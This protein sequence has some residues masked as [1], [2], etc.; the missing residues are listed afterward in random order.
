MAS[1]PHFNLIVAIDANGGIAKNGSMPWNHKSDMKF[2]RDTTIGAG[3]NAVIMGRVTYESIPPAHRP[4]NERLNV[5]VSSTWRQEDKQGITVVPTFVDAL[6]TLGNKRYDTIWVIGGETLYLSVI[7][8]YLY[9]CDKMFITRFKTDYGC[10]KYFP[11]DEVKNFPKFQDELKT[12]DYT[13]YYLK[14]SKDHQEYR[15]IN[16]LREI[17][18]SGDNRADRTGVGTKS[19]FAKTLEFD[20]SERIPLLTVK[21]MVYE[22]VLK[23][24]LF[25][26]SGSTDTKE[27]EAVGVNYWRGNTSRKFLDDR[28][29]NY[30]E[31][32]MGPCFVAGTMI[33]TQN[34][35]KKIEDVLIDDMLY[36]HTGE[37]HSICNLQQRNF[38]GDLF[39]IKARYHPK[40][41]CTDEHPFYCRKYQIKREGKE[42]KNTVIL[43]DPEWI[44]AKDLDKSYL[45]GMPIEQT[46][47]TP[48][49]NGL[50]LD[51]PEYWFM[52][53]YFLGDGWIQ[54]PEQHRIHFAIAD[55]QNN[56]IVSKLRQVLN[57]AIKTSEKTSKC[58]V[59]RVGNK[60]WYEIL[61]HFGKYAHGKKI[62]EWV[63]KAPKNLIEKFLDGYCSADGCIRKTKTNES[64][65]FTTVSP[66]IAYSLQRLYLKLGK[67]ASIS[68]QKRSYK[69]KFSEQRE[70]ESFYRDCYFIEI[71]DSPRRNNYSMIDG[72]HAWFAISNIQKEKTKTKVFNFEVETDNSYIA[73][74]L[75][76]HNCYGFQWRFW[77]AE[78]EGAHENYTGKGIDQL[79]NLICGLRDD[80]LSRR[81][82]MTCLNVADFDRMVLYPCHHTVQFYVSSDR[83]HLDCMM[84]QRSGDMAL[85]VP[86]NIFMYAVLTYMIAHVCNYKPRK[87][88]ITIGDA[89][90]Y[91]SHASGVERMLD[92][93]PRPWATLRFKDPDKI[94]DIDQ[95]KFDNFI[96]ENYT[97]WPFIQLQMAV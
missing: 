95:F 36:T 67:F 17:Y 18:F 86:T 91:N 46:E 87:L 27:L 84:H 74:N 51:K 4:L 42:R 62:P 56:N 8:D 89:H 28:K 66:D 31:G 14:P 5:V 33:A 52:M 92:R 55:S 39:T 70:K 45:I 94:R 22:S 21:K 64:R 59:Y 76:V 38:A 97:S 68:F 25:F 24:I 29:L 93:T 26:V 61:S 3:K 1:L 77:G 60:Q 96:I 49:I 37:L 79:R 34:G 69:K 57:I 16:L 7:K 81:H 30:Q 35:Y 43:D 58:E 13:R 85:G 47:E 41:Q 19:M 11:W 65:R 73:N 83:Q 54:E 12:Q 75:A 63:H 2:F 72:N 90:I 32:D 71:Y 78:Y 50:V 20:I 6:V 44:S 82:I 23:E 40:I 53:G 9:L 80:P 88:T 48:K 15:Y 10:D